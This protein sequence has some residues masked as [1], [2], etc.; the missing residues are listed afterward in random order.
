MMFC[1][2]CG[3]DLVE[4]STPLEEEFKGEL[5]LIEGITRNECPNC[6]EYVMSAHECDALD[7]KLQEEYS[8]SERRKR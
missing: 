2:E 4:V 8:K 7:D 6:G 5:F 3:H 1:P